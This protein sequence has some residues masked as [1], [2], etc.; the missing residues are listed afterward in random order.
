MDFDKI[1]TRAQ[2]IRRNF[3]ENMDNFLLE[4]EE[5]SKKKGINVGWIPDED[6]L[7]RELVRFSEPISYAKFFIDTKH[8]DIFGKIKHQKPQVKQVSIE[9]FEANQNNPDFIVVKGDFGVVENGNIL[10]LDSPIQNSINQLSHLFIVLDINNIVLKQEDLDLLLFLKYGQQMAKDIKI[11]SSKLQISKHDSIQSSLQQN[12]TNDVPVTVL[13]YDNGITSLLKDPELRQILYCI[14]CNLCK[15]CCP[16][17]QITQTFS[18]KELVINFMKPDQIKSKTI[19]EH[20]TLCGNCDK[21]CPVNIPLKELIIKEMILSNMHKGFSDKNSDLFK[22]FSKR[23]K[24]NKINGGL[25]RY[26]FLQKFFGKNKML[27]NYFSNQKEPFF[28]I[29]QQEEKTDEE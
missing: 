17:Y 10:L 29:L 9:E 23:S 22:I 18:P 26:L 25:R 19:F 5:K 3:I 2:L 11:I 16:V 15:N 1:R 14:D 12:D 20:T 27:Y 21:V 4:F 8:L 13:L 6:T 24:M 7:V 28:N